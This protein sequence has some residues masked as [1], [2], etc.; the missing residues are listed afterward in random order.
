MLIFKLLYFFLLNHFVNKVY[1]VI[2]G[3]MYLY[4]I[5]KLYSLKISWRMFDWYYEPNKPLKGCRSRPIPNVP[6]W[7]FSSS[8]A[9][10]FMVILESLKTQY[11]RG[12]IK[13]KYL[14]FYFTI[15]V[16]L[17]LYGC[18]IFTFF[19]RCLL[20]GNMDRRSLKPTF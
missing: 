2:T 8:I 15:V 11:A 20:I 9:V 16:F 5:V 10:L 6:F 3:T 17:R 14:D 4:N 1:C 18:P 19:L 13:V 12:S 7:I